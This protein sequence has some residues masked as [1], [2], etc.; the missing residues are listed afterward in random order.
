MIS[1]IGH[2][3]KVLLWEEVRLEGQL[4]VHVVVES[5]RV[6]W[7]GLWGGLHIEGPGA[8]AH[9]AVTDVQGSQAL[10]DGCESCNIRTRGQLRPVDIFLEILIRPIDVMDP[11][12]M[13]SEIVCSRPF[14]LF[15]STVLH[16]AL[17]VFSLANILVT[18][19]DMSVNIIGSA[20]ASRSKTVGDWTVVRFG[21]PLVVFSTHALAKFT[22]EG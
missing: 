20:K 18:A 19:F 3:L 13:L 9:N 7:S 22:G 2:H 8:R 14:L 12:Q 15:G 5:A 4:L 16:E 21:V 6:S 17:V 10:S 11:L 1:D